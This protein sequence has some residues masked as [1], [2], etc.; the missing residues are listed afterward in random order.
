MNYF[1]E[2]HGKSCVDSHFGIISQWL[3]ETMYHV[4]IKNISDLIREFT[5]KE[6]LRQKYKPDNTTISNFYFLEYKR[7]RRNMKEFYEFEN[8]KHYLSFFMFQNE[9][10]ASYFTFFKPENYMKINYS[11]ESISDLRPTKMSFDFSEDKEKIIKS[12]IGTRT[13]SLQERR[14]K[15][16]KKLN[17]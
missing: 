13:K 5:K 1:A 4:D 6:V 10:Y 14:E 16:F 8:V 9:L 15:I 7:N 11:K 3:K 2:Y 17:I 12:A